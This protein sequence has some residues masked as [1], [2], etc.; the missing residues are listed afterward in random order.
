MTPHLPAATTSSSRRLR[1]AVIGGSVTGPV[2]A[3]LLLH[4]G[5]DVTIYE[6]AAATAPRGGGLIG[7]EHCALDVVDRL[8]IPQQEIVAF[9]S[10]AIVQSVIRDRRATQ[11]VLRTYP[12]RNTTWTLLHKALTKRLPAGVLR[13]GMRVAGLVEHA[14]QPVL[15]FSDGNTETADLVV[16]A[17]GRSSAGRQILDPDRGLHYAGY[18]AHRGLASCAP[19]E[20]HSGD[21]LRLDP[22][23]GAQFNLAPVPD[24][25]DWT[26]YLDCSPVEYHHCFGASPTRRVFALP[27][28]V[29]SSARAHVDECAGRLLPP[30]HAELVRD[31]AVRMAVPVLDITPPSR[32]V[33]PIGS[34]HAVLL[35]DALA[36]VRPHT[37]RGA[38]NGI[39]QAAGLAIAL[40]QHRRYGADLP[41]ALRGWQRRHLPTVVAALRQGPAIGDRLGLGAG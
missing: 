24:G 40:T 34:G 37:A 27:H 7:L 12:G 26:F 19:P 5:L 9:N 35:G 11:T 21:F 32:M 17:D 22:C 38:N 29:S 41:A 13:T 6:A 2:T 25:C 33:W 14:G 20:P 36:P 10:E 1:V 4:A 39:E 3:L 18:V 16:F 15:R 30:E 8:G 31:T 23:P 28:H